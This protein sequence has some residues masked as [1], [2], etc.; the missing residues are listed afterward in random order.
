[1]LSPVEDPKPVEKQTEVMIVKVYAQ[2]M[3]HLI[4][5]NYININ[6]QACTVW[7]VNN[8]P[9]IHTRKKQTELSLNS[10]CT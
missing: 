5:Y 8:K 10:S 4:R 2:V 3:L 7:Q 1:M 9:S 6:H